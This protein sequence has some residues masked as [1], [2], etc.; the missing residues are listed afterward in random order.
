MGVIVEIRA[1]FFP[2]KTKKNKQNKQQCKTLHNY[3]QNLKCL[4]AYS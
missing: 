1:Y 2:V 4:N 3:A